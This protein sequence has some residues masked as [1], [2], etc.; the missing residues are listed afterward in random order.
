MSYYKTEQRSVANYKEMEVRTR[1]YTPERDEWTIL[2][3]PPN[4]SKFIGPL[5]RQIYAKVIDEDVKLF[6]VR[7]AAGN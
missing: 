1:Q 3:W 5:K 2:S 4:E 7:C 6:L